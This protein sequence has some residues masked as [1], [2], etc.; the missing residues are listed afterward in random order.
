MRRYLALATLLLICIPAVLTACGTASLDY[1]DAHRDCLASVEKVERPKITS[2]I[3]NQLKRLAY[4][5]EVYCSFFDDWYRNGFIVSVNDYPHSPNF[6]DP[7]AT[8]GNFS[9][10]A[11]VYCYRN[12]GTPPRE[13]HTSDFCTKL[14]GLSLQ[15]IYFSDAN[16][17]ETFWKQ[18]TG[19][20]SAMPLLLQFTSSDSFYIYLLKLNIIYEH[21][22]SECSNNRCDPNRD[23]IARRLKQNNIADITRLLWEDSKKHGITNSWT[24]MSEIYQS[25]LSTVNE[26][27]FLQENKVNFSN[28]VVTDIGYE[29]QYSLSLQHICESLF[30]LQPG[31]GFRNIELAA[32]RGHLQQCIDAFN[33]G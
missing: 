21:Y 20:T 19:Y 8:T 24:E 7:V 17:E 15:T 23:H 28:I 11:F 4:L 30:F 25:V 9:D 14:Q 13:D 27:G 33:Q 12:S 31:D 22:V 26:I 5:S 6:D 10:I 1:A 32:E 18:N 2:D 16:T 29:T 3:E